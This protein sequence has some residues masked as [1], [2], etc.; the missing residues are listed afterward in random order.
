M[1]LRVAA[2]FSQPKTIRYTLFFLYSLVTVN[3]IVFALIWVG[4]D[5]GVAGTCLERTL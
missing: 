3:S 1:I 5:S 2:M 4:P